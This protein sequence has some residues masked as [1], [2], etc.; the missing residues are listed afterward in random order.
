MILKNATIYTISS[1]I[2]AATPFLLL[3]ILTR[4][5]TPDE[6]GLVSMFTV[7]STIVGA[8]FGLSVNGA[9]NVSL[10][11]KGI[12]R[13][14]YI[15]TAIQVLAFS[16]LLAIFILYFVSSWLVPWLHLP[17][18]WLFVAV[19]MVSAQFLINIVFV[20]WQVEGQALKY[21]SLQIF[22]ST[23]GLIISL[24][25]VLIYKMGWEG[26]LIGMFAP[27]YMVSISCVIYLHISGKAK[28]QFDVAHA[29]DVFKFGVTL[30]P[31][32]IGYIFI[33][34]SDRMMI[35]A[36]LGSH[37]VGNYMASMQVAL[38]IGLIADAVSRAL[39]PWIYRNIGENEPEKKIVVVKVTYLYFSI[40]LLFGALFFMLSPNLVL[41]LG[42]KFRN[43]DRI[44]AWTSLGSSFSGMYLLVVIYIFYEKK[45][46]LLSMI[47]IIVG[48]INLPLS[49]FMIKNWGAVGGAGAY[50]FSQ[51][52]M[53][54]MVWLVAQK[55]HPMPWKLTISQ[56]F[57]KD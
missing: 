35:S 39:S 31:H 44:L 28:W 53:F 43:G 56:L 42:E 51:F 1:A 32:S 36:N 14:Q 12:D 2:S 21:G 25:L 50:A 52:I 11:N 10:F 9:V 29:K 6:Y 8:I 55:C 4:A 27:I 37:E 23:I 17:E 19:G 49:F 30:V 3:P 33:A 13:Q 34:M 22:I 54:I 16:T 57:P 41:F 40:L 5:L 46:E 7:F 18:V 38:G 45:N 15:G 24:A 47:T 48:L 26:R 20:I